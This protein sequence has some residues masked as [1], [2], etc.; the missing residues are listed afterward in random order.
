MRMPPILFEIKDGKLAVRE[1]QATRANLPI[2]VA[3]KAIDLLSPACVDIIVETIRAAE[4]HYGCA[5]GLI[6][7]DTFNKGVAMGGGDENAAK[8]QNIT[9][10]NLQQ[11]QDRTDVHIA[12]IGHTGKDE[13]RGA[14]GSNAHLG[15]VDM[16]VQISVAEGVRTAAITKI[17]DGVEG[18]LTRF[19]VVPVTL[20]HDEDGDAITTA[21]VSD[22]VPLGRAG[23]NKTQ[24]R[25]MALL[26]AALSEDGEPAP[27]TA[28]Y[29]KGVRVVAV[30]RWCDHCFMGGLSPAGT[31]DS[32]KRTFRRAVKDLIALR[33]IDVWDERVWIVPQ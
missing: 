8:D 21:I 5:V 16:M 33:R 19:R 26:E 23:L 4:A 17:N 15:D 22:E 12:L 9:A 27:T 6:I 31:K 32:A 30:E 2:A 13:S 7:I 24:Q 29:P 11:V 10:A 14:R 28:K 1:A 18:V 20:G 25:A 3:G